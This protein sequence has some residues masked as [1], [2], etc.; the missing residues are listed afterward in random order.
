MQLQQRYQILEILG[1]VREDK[2]SLWTLLDIVELVPAEEQQVLS[3]LDKALLVGEQRLS[4]VTD[5]AGLTRAG[6]VEFDPRQKCRSISEG[7]SIYQQKLAD[8]IGWK[9]PAASPDSSDN[10]WF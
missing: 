10:I 9:Y 3:L 7:E 8:L 1:L 6:T 5:E 2:A 4:Q